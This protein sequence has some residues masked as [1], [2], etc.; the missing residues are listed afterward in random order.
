M[1]F[2]Y[3]LNLSANSS[4]STN[5]E[6]DHILGIAGATQGYAVTGVFGNVRTGTTVGAGAL[7]FKTGG[8]SSAGTAATANKRDPNN[9][10]TGSSWT[11]AITSA[12]SPIVRISVGLSQTGLQNGWVALDPELDPIRVAPGVTNKGELFSICN[13]ATQ[14]IDMGVVFMES[15]GG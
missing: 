1:P 7:R 11:T 5:T 8:T 10:A 13:T 14:G 9:P 4:G 6:V 12:G 3:D 15:G 2:A